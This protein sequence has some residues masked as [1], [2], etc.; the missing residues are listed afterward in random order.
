MKNL[1]ALPVLLVSTLAFA[2]EADLTQLVWLTGH[3]TGD[4]FGGT[5][6][7][8]WSPPN[9]NLMMGMYRHYKDDG[10]INFYEFMLIDATGL[11]LKHF[12]SDMTGW[13]TKDEYLTFKFES[14]ETNRIVFRGLT[15][16][17]TSDDTMDISLKMK[18][19]EAFHTEIFHMTRVPE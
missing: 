16:E 19:G 2:D 13:E 1:L 4:A 9:N 5:S 15:F 12:N 10:S 6:E 14:Q 11:K 3:W 17:K 8:I 18:Q 7:E